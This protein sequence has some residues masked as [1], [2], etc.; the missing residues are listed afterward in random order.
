MVARG[1]HA[2]T[3]RLIGRVCAKSVDIAILVRMH[4]WP[5]DRPCV[6]SCAALELKSPPRY[7]IRAPNKQVPILHVNAEAV[8]DVMLVSSM[9]H[10]PSDIGICNRPIKSLTPFTRIS[11]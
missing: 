6:C 1:V 3:G 5:A 10:P 4:A 8:D 2:M 7:I 9:H 11:D